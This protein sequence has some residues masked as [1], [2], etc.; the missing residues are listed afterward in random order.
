[1]R[2]GALLLRDT[3]DLALASLALL[4]GAAQ[5]APFGLVLPGPGGWIASGTAAA[6]WTGP[7][8]WMI[9]A[10]GRASGDFAAALAAAAPGCAVTEQTD[11]WA[12]FDFEGPAAA[13]DRLIERL[14]NIDPGQLAPGRATRT[15]LHHMG[16]FVI[17]R[18]PDIL[19]VLVGRS[20]AAS[21][22]HALET[23]ALHLE[24][25]TV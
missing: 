20:F 17:R 10:A 13:I 16:V 25:E 19:G 7:D 12:G 8:Q 14:V 11:G 9:E 5:P 24:A 4:R 23:A 21:L 2:L 3:P 18:A 1:M 15:G 22:R 6:F